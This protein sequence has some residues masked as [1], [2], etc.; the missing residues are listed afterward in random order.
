[1]FYSNTRDSPD[2][3]NLG[4]GVPV[5]EK[6]ANY[7][8]DV[9]VNRHLGE[10]TSLLVGGSYR[11]ETV[12]TADA[13]GAQTLISHPVPTSRGSVFGQIRESLTKRLILTG[14]LRLDASTLYA[15]QYS[16]RASAVYRF[17]PTQS[18][19][20]SFGDAFEA[21]NYA[22][23][24]VFLPIGL[25]ANL[26]P[27]EAG[28][29]SLLGG[30][31]LGLNSVPVFAIG[32]QHL[33]VEHVRSAEVGYKRVFHNRT[34]ITLDYY[35]NWMKDFISDLVPGADP[36]Y[37]LYQAPAALSP[38]TR[39]L[40]SETLNQLVPGLT[41]G[42]GG[43]PWIVYSQAN[44]GH[45]S[46]QGVEASASGW[47]GSSWQYNAN[48]SWFYYSLNDAA[49]RA[50]VHPNAP[51][52]KAFASLGYRKPRF[53]ADLRYRWVD[54]F[55]FASGIFR[56]PVPTYNV[57][58]LGATYQLSSHWKLGLNVSNLLDNRHYEEFGGDILKRLVLGFVAYSWK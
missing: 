42:P 29:A 48:Y 57:V 12:T 56:G 40:V 3:P 35:R 23:L 53:L 19:F 25:P 22:E 52:H 2:E 36:D 15:K 46:T 41:N 51:V 55:Y 8:S 13:K 44:G 58:D 49:A 54:D 7:H 14:A 43:V 38:S 27:I 16:P 4:S 17:T 30:V 1:L 50:T 18:I 21:P 9:Q 33:R 45:V 5:W 32:N 26:S 28:F 34:L 39:A 6:D 11:Y 10:H 20:A 31:S 37:P 47:L 24:Y